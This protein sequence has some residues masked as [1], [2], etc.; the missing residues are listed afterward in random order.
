MPVVVAVAG[1]GAGSGAVIAGSGSGDTVRGGVALLASGRTILTGFVQGTSSIMRGFDVEAMHST[2]GVLGRDVTFAAGLASAPLRR[3]LVRPRGG[4]EVP[5]PG[6]SGSRLFRAP[7]GAS[8]VLRPSTC[9][10]V[11]AC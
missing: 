2:L 4:R 8:R 5:V 11:F 9:W 7:A 1:A 6:T 10:L 3:F